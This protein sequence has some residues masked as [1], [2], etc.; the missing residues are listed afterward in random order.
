MDVYL[1]SVS[2]LK[3]CVKDGLISLSGVKVLETFYDCGKNTWFAEQIPTF[4]KFIL[5]SGAFTFLNSKSNATLDWNRYADAYADFIKSHNVEH[6]FELDIDPI[7][8]I[9]GVE[10]IR[11]RIESKVGR[12]TIP[13]WHRNRGK[14]YYL[15]M[16]KEYKYVAI[17]GLVTSVRDKKAIEPH[18][19]WFINVAHA[20]KCKIHGLGYTSTANLHTRHFDSVDSTSWKIG[21]RIGFYSKFDKKTGTIATEYKKEGQRIKNYRLIFANDFREWVKFQKYAETYL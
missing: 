17:G 18:L 11:H 15:D 9:R 19:P 16:C 3:N 7:L 13:V 20:N 14:Q 4:K 1:A 2:G 8:G 5:D 12:Q 10:K 21:A 6:F